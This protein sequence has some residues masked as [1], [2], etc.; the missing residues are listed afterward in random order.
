MK[1]FAINTMLSY[2]GI[3]SQVVSSQY[4]SGKIPVDYNPS[5]SAI[6]FSIK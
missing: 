5:K 1:I 6:F 4:I 2:L 3:N